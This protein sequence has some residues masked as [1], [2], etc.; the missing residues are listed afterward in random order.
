ME[1][2]SPGQIEALT[3]P[4]CSTCGV[5][6]SDQVCQECSV[7]ATRPPELSFRRFLINTLHELTDLDSRLLTTLHALLLKPGLL[8]REY[9]AGRGQRF[10]SP[11]RLFL[12]VNIAY[13]IARSLFLQSDTFTT[14]LHTQLQTIPALGFKTALVARKLAAEHTS[15]AAL[16]TR[17]DAVA[18]EHGKTLIILLI[19]IYA[20]VLA[21]ILLYRRRPLVQHVVFATHFVTVVVIALTLIPAVM[22]PVYF[23]GRAAGVNL[24]FLGTDVGGSLL[25]GALLMVYLIPALQ[26][27]YDL[28][29]P[30]AFLVAPLLVSGLLIALQ[31]YRFAL[32]FTVYAAV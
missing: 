32:F 15:M 19:P 25:V 31:F 2:N 23:L 4:R 22:A 7:R 16:A 17:W 26:R 9:V 12:L 24:Q 6:L 8:T 27:G 30:A 11:L 10:V 20:A 14:T 1:R 18:G 13:F 3:A 28:G 29:R 5:A 21:I